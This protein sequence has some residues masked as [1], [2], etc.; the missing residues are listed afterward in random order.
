MFA[1]EIEKGRQANKMENWG[2]WRNDNDKC[3]GSTKGG[4]ALEWICM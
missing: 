2:S 3:S 4:V 1:A